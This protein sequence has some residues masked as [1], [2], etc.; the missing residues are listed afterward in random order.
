VALERGEHD[1]A[2]VRFVAVVEHEAGH[3][4]SLTPRGRADIH[5]TP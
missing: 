3:G 1:T 4:A 2:F 5:G